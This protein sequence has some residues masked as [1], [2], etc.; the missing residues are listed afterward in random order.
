[1]K[2]HT[3]W[4]S[5]FIIAVALSFGAAGTHFAAAQSLLPP[6]SSPAAVP[7]PA[8]PTSIQAK[9][10]ITT[11]TT[12]T[13]PPTLAPPG[14]SGKPSSPTTG[15]ALPDGG[16]VKARSPGM[17]L[18]PEAGLPAGPAGL[19][20]LPQKTP[21]EIKS[22]IRD[23]AFN[24]AITGLLPLDP[25]E[26]RKLLKRFDETKEA[27]ETPIYPYPEPQS[28]VKNISLDPG[29]RP[30]ELKLATGNVT[31]VTILDVTGAPWPIAHM[32]WAGNFTVTPPPSGSNMFVITPMSEFAAGNVSIAMI[33][34]VTPITFVLRTHRDE[35][36]YR[37]DARLPDYGPYAQQPLIDKGVTIAAGN[38]SMTA[39]LD[40]VP[41]ES[42]KK[43]EVSGVDG[44]TTA[45]KYNEAT[46]VRTPLT[47]LSP[48][49]SGSVKSGDGMNVYALDNAPVI[50]LSDQGRMVR[51]RLSERNEKK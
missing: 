36:Y 17:E 35:V 51:A 31:T 7:T 40:G 21:E 48:A 20:S 28:V 30:L 4:L 16:T 34:L 9:Q 32:T 45:Y 3:V 18:P 25:P 24:A 12:T 5:A 37:V 29:V 38:P 13:P 10:T 14:A 2:I 26:I 8:M 47:L 42:A 33:G 19:G 23:D 41:P 6:S 44:R 15:S 50:L 11:T 46:Y 27:T 39:I 49:W 1:M 22:E 43:L